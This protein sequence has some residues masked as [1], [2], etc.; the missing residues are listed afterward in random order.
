VNLEALMVG[1]NAGFGRTLLSGSGI[2]V[3]SGALARHAMA[4]LPREPSAPVRGIA[5]ASGDA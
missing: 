1:S 5:T 2:I 4:M 3:F